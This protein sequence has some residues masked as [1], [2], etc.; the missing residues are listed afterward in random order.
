MEPGACEVI[1]KIRFVLP[2]SLHF[3]NLSFILGLDEIP[4]AKSTEKIHS[5]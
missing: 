5:F 4:L 1:R 2:I 3:I